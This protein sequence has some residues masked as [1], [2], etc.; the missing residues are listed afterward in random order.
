VHEGHV[1]ET[2]EA[3]QVPQV[4]LLEV[5]AAAGPSL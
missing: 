2:D 1:G 4:R 3:Q 5:D